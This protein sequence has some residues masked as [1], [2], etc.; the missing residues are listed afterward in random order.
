MTGLIDAHSHYMPQEIA[1]NTMFFKVGWSDVDRHL[2][3]MDQY[4]IERAVLLYPTSDA[5]L[6]MGGWS[7][8]CRVYNEAIARIVKNHPSRFVGGG[9]LP[10]DNAQTLQEEL[11]YLQDSDV[12][13]ISLASSYDGRFLSDD[14]FYPVYEYAQ[15]ANIPIH[16]HA[17][18]LN[19]IG[20][21][22]VKDPLLSPVLEYVFD[23]SMCVG[24]M[25]MCGVFDRFPQVNFIVAHYGG[26]LPIVKERFDNTYVMLRKRNFV[27]DIGRLPGEFFQNLYLDT[28][29]SKSVAAL[30]AALELVDASHILY[31]SDFPANQSMGDSI[32]M[33]NKTALSEHEK[34]AILYENM[35]KLLSQD[36]YFVK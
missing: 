7:K 16:I 19:P 5:H 4:R 1:R 18:I 23:V 6:N 15:R 21:E 29:G 9:L 36:S 34:Q 8:V 30:H 35:G 27:K 32:D 31:G 11:K 25:M 12:K 17:Q 3:V 26:V 22:R 2:A 20:E 33:L 13:I 28:S 24:Q 14:L 10:P